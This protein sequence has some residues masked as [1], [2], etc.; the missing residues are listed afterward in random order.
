MFQQFEVQ[1]DPRNGPIRLA[2]L[3]KEL[4]E[5]KLTGFLVPHADEHQGEY[6]P[7]RAE[8][9]SWLTG[10]TASAGAA[11][12][13]STKAAVF[14][15]GRYT[16]QVRQQVDQTAF[17]PVFVSDTRPEE[18]LAANV[19]KGDRIGFDPWLHTAAEIDR[20]RKALA[21]KKL[22]ELVPV[23]TNPIDAVWPDQPDGPLGEIIPHPRELAGLSS[24]QKRLQI[25]ELLADKGED[26]TV[27]TLPDSIA[28]LLNIRGADL[29][30]T[31]FALSFA[32]LTKEG[33]L[34]FFVDDRKLTQEARGYLGN[35]INIRKPDEFIPAL[36][37]L[38]G[39]VVHLDDKTAAERIR[40]ELEKAG[41]EIV[42]GQD[43]C[44]LPKACKN[45][46]ELEGMRDAHVRDGGA[47]SKFLCF[48]SKEAAKGGLDEIKAAK[49]LEGFRAENGALKDLSFDTISG[50]GPH[51]AMPHYRVNTDTNR[52][53]NAG[54]LYLVDSGGQYTDGTTDIT[55]TIAVGEPTDEMRDRFT[56]VLKGHIALAMAKFPAGTRGCHLDILARQPLWDAGL[57]YDHGTGH[58]VGAHLSV[59]EGPQNISKGLVDVPLKEG[60]ICSNEPGFYKEGEYGIRIENLVIVTPAEA[61]DGGERPMHGFETITL[62]P[63]DLNLVEKNLLTDAEITWLN[64]YHVR[65]FESLSGDVDEETKA[66]L[67]EA[68]Q[69]I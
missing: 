55:R 69:A 40:S 48:M 13:L 52:P 18:W 15:D 32:I 51:G 23:Q 5:R 67:V 26:A 43:P 65:V 21:E 22:A 24:E 35:A 68:T 58:G 49:K 31:P 34:D 45:P 62:A 54:E 14:Y 63:I 27:L 9:L 30:H 42:K 61:I 33:R 16:V 46:A 66:W 25:G 64:N 7:A 11:I 37:D 59:H 19:S 3:R 28:W 1:T 10:F 60:M 57:D 56:R 6:L 20:Y 38:A 17:T 4:S 36:G 29:P 8:R 41:A 53:I 2:S 50:A 12:V 47:V 44:L 39:K